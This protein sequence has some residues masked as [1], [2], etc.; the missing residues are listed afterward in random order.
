[1]CAGYEDHMSELLTVG[2]GTAG[3]DRLRALIRDA[4]GEQLV[5]IRRYPGSRR[6]PDLAS[7]A[8]ATWLPAAG[9]G[10][11]HEPR[12]GGRRR[13]A[14]GEPSPD[15]W[16]RV[17]AF[18]AYA[19]YMRTDEFGSALGD[20]VHGLDDARTLVMCSETL[21]W[22][23]HRRLVSDAAVLLHG[24]TV[25]HLGHD[26]RLSPHP[27]SEGARVVSGQLVYDRATTARGPAH[28]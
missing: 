8:M 17:D 10:Y 2:H 25:L 15:T 21:W 24:I 18:R 7:D 5:D 16:W 11:R 9:I 3:Q 26:G 27:P 1:M 23:C 22:R 6:D 20:L 28:S 19:A 4:G 13:L 12:L 14:P